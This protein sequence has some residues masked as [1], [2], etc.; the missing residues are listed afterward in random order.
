MKSN[1]YL[2]ITKEQKGPL[3]SSWSTSLSKLNK[4]DCYHV[5]LQN[6]ITFKFCILR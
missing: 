4:T 2:T 5:E 3:E 6:Q 1:A